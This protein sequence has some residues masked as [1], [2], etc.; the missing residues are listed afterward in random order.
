ME[1][2]GKEFME[3]GKAQLQ[4]IEVQFASCKRRVNCVA[5]ALADRGEGGNVAY[6][7]IGSLPNGFNK[8]LAL[9]ERKQFRPIVGES[10]RP[11]QMAE[12]PPSPRPPDDPKM[13]DEE[14]QIAD[15]EDDPA[16]ESA[17]PNYLD[18]NPI[19]RMLGKEE[20]NQGKQKLIHKFADEDG[21]HTGPG[22][23]HMKS[24]Q[25]LRTTDHPGAADALLCLLPERGSVNMH[26]FGGWADLVLLKVGCRMKASLKARMFASVF[27]EKGCEGT[28]WTKCRALHGVVLA[29]FLRV[30]A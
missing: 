5:V 25:E 23:R 22:L 6:G 26:S 11:E 16:C 29:D 19:D 9:E 13:A 17:K 3:S 20:G 8:L 4:D 1:S 24:R 27:E 14:D 2:D 15:Q 21:S 28:P 12:T 7:S 30:G 18:N 10:D